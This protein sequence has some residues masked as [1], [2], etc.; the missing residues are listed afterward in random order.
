[1]I[2]IILQAVF[3]SEFI[4]K[5]FFSSWVEFSSLGY[6]RKIIQCYSHKQRVCHTAA[7]PF[8]LKRYLKSK[9]ELWK[10]KYFTMH[11]YINL[12]KIL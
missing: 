6:K 5:V 11:K 3:E 7:L 4:R 2:V 8:T 9:E 10:L 1:M 12:L